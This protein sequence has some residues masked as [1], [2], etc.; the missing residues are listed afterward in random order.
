MA[1]RAENRRATLLAL[2]EAAID[3]FESDGPTVTVDAIAERA[4]VSRRTVFRHV[5][6]K[7]ELAFIHP[8]L[9]FDAFDAALA[10]N[11]Q[12]PVGERLRL[13]SMAIAAEIDADPEPPRRAFLV[14]SVHPG[15]Y[16]GFQS[17][18]QRWVDRI[19]EVV[20]QADAKTIAAGG[21]A[22]DVSADPF[23]ARIVGSAV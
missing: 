15:L 11:E 8:L 18:Y 7:E 19:A 21:S 4:G 3:L 22:T 14:A 13:A 17:L 20:A 23:R 16:R 10:A 5:E 12:V 1:T 6:S 9:W 2:S